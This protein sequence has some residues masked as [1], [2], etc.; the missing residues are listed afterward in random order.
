MLFRLVHKLSKGC[1]EMVIK[2]HK[3]ARKSKSSPY[4]RILRA[5]FEYRAEYSNSR[6]KMYSFYTFVAAAVH[7]RNCNCRYF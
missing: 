3:K 4:Y 2:G 5:E 6:N 1:R 7:G